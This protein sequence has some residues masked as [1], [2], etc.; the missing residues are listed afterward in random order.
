MNTLLRD[1]WLVA[2]RATDRFAQGRECDYAMTEHD[3]DRYDPLGLLAELA[4]ISELHWTHTTGN[5]GIETCAPGASLDRRISESLAREVG[6]DPKWLPELCE[7]T[8]AG[9]PGDAIANWVT[10]HV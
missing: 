3:A 4:D 7:L 10:A 5:R 1:R 9:W 6:L 8:D 2:L